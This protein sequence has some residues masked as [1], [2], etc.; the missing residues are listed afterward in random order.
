MVLIGEAGIGKTRLAE[1]LLTVAGQ[2]GALTAQARTYAAA[3]RLAY[4]PPIDW[5]RTPALHQRLAQLN[6]AD[7]SELAR[8]MPETLNMRTVLTL[9]NPAPESLQRTRLF[10]A[11]T[12][13]L[14]VDRQPLL[15]LLDDL[16]WSDQE[17]L[18]WLHFLLRHDPSAPLLVVATLRAGDAA[19]DALRPWWMALVRDEQ[20]SVIELGGWTRR[21]RWRWPSSFHPMR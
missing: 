7:L 4:A 1:E 11:L 17:T 9:P 16:Q 3:G 13:A 20:A 15:L 19:V 5:L 12:R 10:E 21:R 18:D 8:L 6:D 14:L 2:Q